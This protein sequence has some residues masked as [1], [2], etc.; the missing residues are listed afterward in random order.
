MRG[1]PAVPIIPAEVASAFAAFPEPVRAQLLEVRR[2]IFA[3]AAE[4][5]G[6]EPLTETLKWGEPAYLTEATG[7]G[8]TIRL[9]LPAS[10]EG[11]GAVL[12]NCRT[13]LVETFRAQFAEA[14]VFQGNRALLL[15]PSAPLPTEQ[16]SMCLAM[17]LTYHRRRAA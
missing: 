4:T 6:V 13:P 3:T 14:F 11:M 9:G 1:A 17:A 2:L 16:L 15:D 7:S 12:F 5:G 8:S 10:T